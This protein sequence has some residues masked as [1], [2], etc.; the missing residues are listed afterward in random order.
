MVAAIRTGLGKVPDS[1]LIALGTRPADG[2]HW[3]AKLLKGGAA[4]SQV[5][6]TPAGRSAVP[7]AD[8]APGESVP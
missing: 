6:A 5:H 2:A 1:R 7:D 8:L 4:Y 3:F